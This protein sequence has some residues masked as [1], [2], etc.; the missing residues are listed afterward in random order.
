MN[1]K[2][3]IFRVV[4][5]E[6]T[7]AEETDRVVECAVMSAHPFGKEE[8]RVGYWQSSSSLFDPGI[9]IPPDAS[10]VHH[11]TDEDVKGCRAFLDIRPG[12]EDGWFDGDV[13][14][15]HFA[16]FDAG[17]VPQ[18]KGKPIVC[19]YRL[20]RHLWP[21]LDQYK[22]QYLRYLHRL[23][24]PDHVRAMPAH[25]A[26]PDAWVTAALLNFELE[27]LSELKPE[28]ET[29]EQLIEWTSGPFLLY[30]I[31]F[32]KYG[33]RGA[34]NPGPKGRLWSEV[35]SEY[36]K[37]L[38]NQW[39]KSGTGDADPDTVFTVFHYLEAADKRKAVVTTP[40]PISQQQTK[41]LF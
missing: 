28:I 35:P 18:I 30:R 9:P 31:G 33:P 7:G 26:F 14:A 41:A 12:V 39:D 36:L 20:A 3:T 34:E 29:V 32:G 24:I 17:F 1:L 40:A 6:T 15:A 8:C 4:D 10:A 13:Y 38:V 2:S 27:V 19:T 25:R 23:P 5:V 16:E 37:W 22:N 11:I 21:T